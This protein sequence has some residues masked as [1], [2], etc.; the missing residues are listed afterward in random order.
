MKPGFLAP[1]GSLSLKPRHG[2]PCN[3]CGLCCM[4]TLCPLGEAVLGRRAGP[5]PALRG[6][7][8]DA[9]C[10]LVEDPAAFVGVRRVM[11]AGGTA[12]LREAAVLLIGSGTG[13]DARMNGEPPDVGFYLTLRRLDHLARDR[14]PAALRAWGVER[15]F[16][17]AKDRT[18]G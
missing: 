4:A 18:D 13:C 14:V 1:R 16:K 2:Q 5:C 12:V 11:E 10:G 7:I 3:R 9:R 6:T 8:G 15:F 17:R